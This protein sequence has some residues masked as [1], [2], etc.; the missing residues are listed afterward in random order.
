MRGSLPL[1]LL[2]SALGFFYAFVRK[3]TVTALWGAHCGLALKRARSVR[4][5]R[6]ATPA[7]EKSSVGFQCALRVFVHACFAAV[8]RRHCFKGSTCFQ[9]QVLLTSCQSSYLSHLLDHRSA[10]QLWA[11]RA[12]PEPCAWAVRRFAHSL[13]LLVFFQ[14]FRFLW[15]NLAQMSLM[16]KNGFDTKRLRR[17]KSTV[18]VLSGSH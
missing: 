10:E 8:L 6:S 2:V 15:L 1:H 3:I 12:Y 18:F 4:G 11:T 16:E 13:C 7:Q 9:I 14:C 5:V 17:S